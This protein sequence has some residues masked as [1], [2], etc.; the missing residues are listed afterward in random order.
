MNHFIIG[1][2]WISRSESELGLGI[3]IDSTSSRVTVLFLAANERRVYAVDNAP[4][5]RVQFLLGDLIENDDGFSGVITDISEQEGLIRYQMRCEDNDELISFDEMALNAHL[6]FNKPQERLF[7]GQAEAGRW[8]S[9]RY[10]TWQHKQRL[11][12]SDVAG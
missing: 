5:T 4:L 6:Q 12:Q 10:D 2:R 3:I 11:Q 8:F 1:Q 7:M 9:L